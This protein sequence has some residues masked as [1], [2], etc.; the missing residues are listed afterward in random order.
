[1][2]NIFL[3]DGEDLVLRASS[4]PDF[5]Q[6]IDRLR[7]R[8]GQEGINGWV[9]K[10]GE[11][12]NVPDVRQDSRY[13]YEKEVE[14]RT[15]SELAVPILLKGAVI[16]VLDTQS[17]EEG[18]F[19]E[20]DVFTLQTVAGQLAVAIE[21]ARLYGE[22]QKE[23][24]ARKRTEKLLR[25]LHVA[26]LAMEM[27]VSP[28]EVFVTVGEELGRVGFLCALHLVS[29]DRREVS[30]AYSSPALGE[31]GSSA[32]SDGRI[33]EAIRGGSHAVYQK[34]EIVAPL[35]F[36]DRL[37]GFLTVISAELSVDD[38]PA[39]QV[40]ANEI[41]A[42]WRKA[43]LVGEL[44]RSVRD[45]ERTQEQ[46]I[47]SQKMEAVGRLAGGVAH[48]FNNQLTAIMG[49][50]D[51]LLAGFAEDD[52]RR[53]EVEEILRAAGRAAE[54]TRQLLAFSRRQVLRPRVVDLNELVGE[55]R[56]MLQRLIGENIRLRTIS[57]EGPMRVRADPAQLEQV[58]MNLAVNARDAMPEGGLLEIATRTDPARGGH[59]GG[60]FHVL[61]VTDTGTGM[62]PEVM[63][64][65]FE[66]FF[67]TKEPGRGTGLGLS[68]VYGIV[69]QSG[70]SIACRSAL[71]EGTTFEISLPATGETLSEP[72]RAPEP[73]V[74]GGK[75]RI[76]VIEDEL[77]VRE[78]VARILAGA[79]Y[80]VLTAASGDEGN[81][82]LEKQKDVR[83]V[84]TDLMLP[85]SVSGIDIARRVH[86]GTRGVGLLCISGYS[87][88]LVSGA[89][90]LPAG[91]AL[92][93]KPFNAAELLKKVR[94]VLDEKSLA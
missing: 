88:Q 22:L 48:D 6:S 72:Q 19:Q 70:G 49:Y 28:D 85:G 7:L 2:V 35:L 47:Q 43:H 26:G 86:A 81:D 82:L 62:S 15:R 5:A 25:A 66:P 31:P 80:S 94:T 40:F 38:I 13:R 64:R 10:S 58:I 74:A 24:A 78:L 3:A 51:F 92:L 53:L 83:M 69:K 63:S 76:L 84:I 39:M 32:P 44:R 52:A 89:S 29:E 9:A 65:L 34:G 11:P 36:E 50:A 41:A 8:I 14:K 79:G 18:A 42:A 59:P 77:Q 1:M 55:M 21:N 56:G 4:M 23:L 27:A 54:L 33:F 20:L 90:A 91:A 68:T 61:S 17:E 57:A 87:E 93:Q 75:E 67:T 16:G 45:L 71:A 37:L 46:L 73:V 12:L 30:P 60:P